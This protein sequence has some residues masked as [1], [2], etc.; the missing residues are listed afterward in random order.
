MSPFTKTVF[1]QSDLSSD[2]V[3]TTIVVSLILAI[4]KASSLSGLEAR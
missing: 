3:K 2:L 1:S 4:P